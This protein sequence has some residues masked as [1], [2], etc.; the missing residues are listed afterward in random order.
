MSHKINT[1]QVEGDGGRLLELDKTD[2][3]P[4]LS[5]ATITAAVGAV[6]ALAISFGV[7]LS[8]GQQT[9]ITTVAVVAAPLIAAWWARRKSWSGKTVTEV[10]EH[11][12]D[13][14]TRP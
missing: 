5:R 3:E 4:L 6:L 11:V 12:E 13:Q 10:V 2:R 8:D 9:A 14:V 1:R 7:D